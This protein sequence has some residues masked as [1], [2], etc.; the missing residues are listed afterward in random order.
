MLRIGIDVG[1]TTMKTTALDEQNNLVYSDYQ[2][3]YSQ[4]IEKGKEML[5]RMMESIGD[6]L[7]TISLSGSAGM[8]LA[9]AAGIPF[10][11]EVYATRIAAKTF[12]PDT[13]TIIELGG[14]DAKILFLKNSLKAFSRIEKLSI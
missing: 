11:Q 5:S 8:G 9:E 2:R 6:G 12:I 10:V 7:V 1:S 4:I 3:H 14:E 13:D